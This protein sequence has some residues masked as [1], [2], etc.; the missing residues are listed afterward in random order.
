[1]KSK[2]TSG[3]DKTI[4]LIKRAKSIIP[5]KK[6]DKAMSAWWPKYKMEEKDLEERKL[7]LHK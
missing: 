5:K 6:N 7:N 2:N 1:M 4:S 3:N